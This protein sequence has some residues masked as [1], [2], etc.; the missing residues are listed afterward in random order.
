MPTDDDFLDA[1]DIGD[2]MWSHKGSE[3]SWTLGKAVEMEGQVLTL[4]DTGG[5]TWQVDWSKDEVFPANKA[6][7]E[8]LANMEYINGACWTRSCCANA[9]RADLRP[10]AQAAAL[11]RPAALK[12]R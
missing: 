7:V 8:D 3:T 2:S 5:S 12:P 4:S 6:T 1:A 9:A 10:A 11:W